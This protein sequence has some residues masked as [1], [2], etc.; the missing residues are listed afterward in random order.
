MQTNVANDDR[1]K[2]L[3][4]TAYALSGRLDILFNNVGVAIPGTSAEMSEEAWQKVIN[5]NLGGVFRCCKYAL[6]YMLKQNKGTIVNCSST[7]A[8]RGFMGWAGYAASK[9]GILALTKQLAIEYAKQGIRVNA[10]EPG[11]IMTPM[12]ERIFEEVEDRQALID[13]W[14]EAHPVGQF[15]QPEEVG[16]LVPYLCSEEDSFITGQSF[17]IDG[18]LSVRGE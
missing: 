17:V 11:T 7:Q 10:V 14:N 8:N 16:D 9:G 13:L 6:P 4:D 18:G 15:D 1:V 12:N 2:S 3:M 5:I